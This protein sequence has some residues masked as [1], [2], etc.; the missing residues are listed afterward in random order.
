MASLDTDLKNV[1]D[2]I[3]QFARQPLKDS[4][5]ELLINGNWCGHG[6]ETYRVYDIADN[7]DFIFEVQLPNIETEELFPKAVKVTST[8]SNKQ[9]L[10]YDTRKHPA[11]FYSSPDYAE[12]K[13]EFDDIYCCDKCSGRK[14]KISVGFEVPEDADSPNDTTWFALAT[15]CVRCGNK[16]ILLK[17]KQRK[18]KN[19]L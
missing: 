1:P 4:A 17:M 19:T 13:S 14:F 8:N 9:F 16:T 5:A 15:E 18:S 12:K 2:Y 11:S 3:R 7:D 6:E 10:I